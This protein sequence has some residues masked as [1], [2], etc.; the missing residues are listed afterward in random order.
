MKIKL[1]L[2]LFLAIQQTL[3]AQRSPLR[4]FYVD[5][6]S[7]P[8]AHDLK[9][10]I[11]QNRYGHSFL[12]I[13]HL[14]L[15]LYA[16]DTFV[17]L[18]RDKRKAELMREETSSKMQ[19]LNAR[20]VGQQ[21]YPDSIVEG[22]HEVIVTDNLAFCRDAKVNVIGN[23]IREII[24][25]NSIPLDFVASG[26]IKNGKNMV[27]IKSFDGQKVRVADVFFINDLEEP[28]VTSAPLEPSVVTFFSSNLDTRIR[29]DGRY[30]EPFTK[31]FNNKS[32]PTCGEVGTVSIIVPPGGY[33][34]EVKKRGFD[35]TSTFE[36]KPGKCLL[37]EVR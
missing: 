30:L 11:N 27:T 8:V 14:N 22:W 4:Q 31:S 33:T 36:A 12:L 23:R 10:S 9:T 7:I 25:E 3:F 13:N 15:G 21:S 17:G 19:M 20:Y 24:I 1:S 5:L 6:K 26:A 35:Y 29:M 32:M 37:L 28:N 34:Y 16:F 2:I 18:Y